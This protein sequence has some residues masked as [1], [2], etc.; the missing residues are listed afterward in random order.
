MTDWQRLEQVIR[1]TGLSTNAFAFSIGLKRSQNLYQ[2]K[3]QRNRISK[4]LADRI[5]R[6]YPVFD[7]SWL[8]TGDGPAPDLAALPLS[9]RPDP[10]AGSIPFYRV[11]ALR[12]ASDPAAVL[13]GEPDSYLS[14]PGFGD[15]D[16][17]ALCTG[18]RMAPEIPAGS[19]VVLRSVDP[20][21]PVL[22][23]EIYLLVSS[24]YV[25]MGYIR[26]DRKIADGLWLDPPEESDEDSVGIRRD[27]I[28]RLY[29]VL[30]IVIR[31][32]L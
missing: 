27:R 2:I 12:L 8:L 13:S 10:C 4:D 25:R 16:L 24:E 29:L 1:W 11:D 19:I 3:R 26:S 5:V 7:R 9:P 6:R 14:I 23:G 30:G 22:P 21:G 31:K 32:V 28:L 18:D 15:C 20:R 17:A